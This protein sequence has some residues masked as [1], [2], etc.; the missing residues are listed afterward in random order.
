L[1][2]TNVR[3]KSCLNIIQDLYEIFLSSGCCRQSHFQISPFNVGEQ[4]IPPLLSALAIITWSRPDF[5]LPWDIVPNN[6][7]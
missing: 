7:L 5:F 4:E 6:I 3:A 1:R 2:N